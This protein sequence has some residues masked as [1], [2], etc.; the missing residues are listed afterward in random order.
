SL[1]IWLEHLNYNAKQGFFSITF[2]AH[3]H[4]RWFIVSHVLR[5]QLTEVINKKR[6]TVV[7]VALIAKREWNSFRTQNP[8]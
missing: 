2:V 5:A 3:P 1:L 6:A 4:S 8:E 7:T